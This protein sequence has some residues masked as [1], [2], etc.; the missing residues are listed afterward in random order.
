MLL[1]Y[2]DERSPEELIGQTL[3]INIALIPRLQ[4][5]TGALFEV[6]LGWIKGS[7]LQARLGFR[8]GRRPFAA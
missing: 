2:F 3:A 6:T 8:S 7:S 4:E 5:V 1:D